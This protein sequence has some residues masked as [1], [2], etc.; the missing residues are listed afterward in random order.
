MRSSTAGSVDEPHFWCMMGDSE[1]REGSLLEA[2]PEVAERELGNVTWIIDYN[3]QNLDGTRIPNNRGLEGTDADRIER[4]AV[5]NGWHVIQLRHGSFRLAGLRAPGRRR[6]AQGIRA[7]L[8]RTT[9]TRRCSGSATP[10]R[11]ARQFAASDKSCQKLLESLKD[12]EVV[13]LFRDLGGHDHASIVEAFEQCKK[14]ST[15]R[16][17]SSRTR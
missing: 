17:S 12:D 16:R 6:A 1:F 9:T 5:A 7:R 2:L 3:R 14:T 8:S 4:T 15:A 11:C 10:C 13:R